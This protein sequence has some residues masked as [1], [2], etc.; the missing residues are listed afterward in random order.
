VVQTY[1]LGFIVE[2]AFAFSDLIFDALPG[3]GDVLPDGP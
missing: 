1:R 3:G 2:K